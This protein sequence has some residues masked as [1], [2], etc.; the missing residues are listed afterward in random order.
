MGN[1]NSLRA[2]APWPGRAKGCTSLLTEGM[3]LTRLQP[4]PQGHLPHWQSEAALDLAGPSLGHCI[5]YLPYSLDPLL[6]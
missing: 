5:R 2:G 1:S 6:N 4:C 3:R